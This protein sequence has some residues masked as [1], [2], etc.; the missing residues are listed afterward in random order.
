M[1]A[2]AYIMLICVGIIFASLFLRMCS[3]TAKVVYKEYSPEAML[4]KYE[5]FKELSGSIDEK[6]ATLEIYESQLKGI[7]DQESF[8]YQQ[9]SAEAL[10]IAAMHNKLCKEYNVAMSEFHYRFCNKGDLPASNLEVLP[11]EIKP[12]ILSLNN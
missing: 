9:L 1:R 10:G 8:N 3:N 11:R 6:R 2:F 4:K 5:Y 7:K 12:Y